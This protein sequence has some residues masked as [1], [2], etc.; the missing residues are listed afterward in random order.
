MEGRGGACTSAKAAVVQGV[1]SKMDTCLW[2]QAE[3]RAAHFPAA[4]AAFCLGWA[5]W[6][7]TSCCACSQ[8]L[9]FLL[10]YKRGQL[11][12]GKCFASPSLEDKVHLPKGC[13]R[14]DAWFLAVWLLLLRSLAGLFEWFRSH[15]KQAGNLPNMLS[16]PTL[17]GL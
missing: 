17:D 9:F 5:P 7:H 3:P 6:T 15:H 1:F 12:H 10:I 4:C 2:K 11:E 16:S 14:P 13:G 8:L